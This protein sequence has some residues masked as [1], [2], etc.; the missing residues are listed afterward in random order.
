VKFLLL[1]AVAAV[2]MAQ[3]RVQDDGKPCDPVDGGSHVLTAEMK[4]MLATVYR[5][6]QVRRQCVAEATENAVDPKWASVASGDYDADGR[7]DQAVLLESKTRPGRR[8]IVVVFMSSI[9]PTPVLAGD[10]SAHISTIPRGRRGH[11]FDI[12]KDFTYMTDAIFT[13]DYHCCGGS[14]IWRKGKFIVVPTSD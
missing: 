2:A 5:S 9:G 13:G 8:T 7:I 6:W 10:G 11:N 12:A 4:S 1:L 14:L 3:A